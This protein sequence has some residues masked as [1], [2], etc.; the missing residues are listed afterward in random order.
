MI[1]LHGFELLS[2]CVIIE[3]GNPKLCFR[4]VTGDPN[5]PAGRIY[6]KTEGVPLPRS[7]TST[8]GSM[9]MRSDIESL[10]AFYWGNVSLVMKTLNTIVIS[11]KDGEYHMIRYKMAT[12]LENIPKEDILE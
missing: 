7:K 2:A 6:I 5:V 12:A 8:K 9:Q 3:H 1:C 4:K 10:D 11:H